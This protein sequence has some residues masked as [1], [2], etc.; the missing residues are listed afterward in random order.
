MSIIIGILVSLFLAITSLSL[1]ERFAEVR[2]EQRIHDVNSILSAIHEYMVDNGGA[3]PRG[4]ASTEKQ[5]GVC[6]SGGEIVCQQ[7]ARECLD[8]SV[9]FKKYLTSVPIDPRYGSLIAT[10]YTVAVDVNKIVTVKACTPEKTIT[11]Q[12]SR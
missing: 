11:I 5:L 9:L 2:N 3:L 12:A 7:A 10:N 4:V 1:T 6:S 8:L